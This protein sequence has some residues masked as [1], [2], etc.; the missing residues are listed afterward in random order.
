MCKPESPAKRPTYHRGWIRKDLRSIS[1]AF[2]EAARLVQT[3]D[4]PADARRVVEIVVRDTTARVKKVFDTFDDGQIDGPAL[5]GASS[6]A[7]EHLLNAK[8]ALLEAELSL[9]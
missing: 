2:D 9:R 5:A 8:A 6:S 3:L 4:S 1:D 7:M